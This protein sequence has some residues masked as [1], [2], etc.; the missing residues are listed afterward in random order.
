MSFTYKYH[1]WL[2][3]CTKIIN[4]K[5]KENERKKI[6]A[7]LTILNLQKETEKVYCEKRYWVEPIFQKRHTHGF[8]HAIFPVISLH[9]SRFRNYFRMTA[10]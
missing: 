1:T 10:M 5:K 2:N 7:T 9:E 8:Y 4:K 3:K 6:F